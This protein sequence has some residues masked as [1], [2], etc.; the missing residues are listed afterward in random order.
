MES[1]A[2]ER[3]WHGHCVKGDRVRGSGPELNPTNPMLR[4]SKECFMRRLTMALVA[5]VLGLMAVGAV[6]AQRGQ[7]DAKSKAAA[8]RRVPKK[9]G[10]DLVI[11]KVTDEGFSIK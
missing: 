11:K 1:V 7:D 6:D 2:A 4:R 10:P 8:K 9:N 5:V 3:P